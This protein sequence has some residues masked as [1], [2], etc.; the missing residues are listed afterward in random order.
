MSN[1]PHLHKKILGMNIL[2]EIKTEK[3][4]RS[5][6]QVSRKKS[7]SMIL[8]FEMILLVVSYVIKNIIL[9]EINFKT[10]EK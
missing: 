3:I 10:F 7:F 8:K 6:N 4:C 9:Y 5:K 2:N 1:F